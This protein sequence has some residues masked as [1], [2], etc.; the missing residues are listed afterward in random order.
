MPRTFFRVF[1]LLAITMLLA[2]LMPRAAQPVK[3]SA[4]GLVI[5]QVYGGGGNS[6]ATYT[7]DFVELF[8]AGSSNVSLNGLSVQYASATGAFTA[9]SKADLPNVSLQP[10]QYFLIQMA[11]GTGGSQP[12]PTPDLVGSSNMSGTA[13]KVALVNGTT[14]ISC[15]GTAGNC[16]SDTSIIDLV[17]FG[18]TANNYEGSG[19]TPAPSNTNSV[20]RLDG[21]CTDT[22]NNSADFE[23]ITAYQTGNPRNTSTTLAPC[24]SPVDNPPAV[25]STTPA[26]GAS[27]VALNS[28]ISITFNEAVTTSASAFNLTCTTGGVRTFAFGGSGASYTLTPDTNLLDSDSCTVTVSAAG[29]TDLDGTPDNMAADYTFSFSTVAPLVCGSAPDKIYELQENGSKYGLGGSFTVDGVVTYSRLGIGGINGFYIQDPVGDGNPNTS[30]AIFVFDPAPVVLNVN[31]GD[32]V[33]ITGTVSEFAQ[34]FSDLQAGVTSVTETQFNI[35]AGELCTNSASITPTVVTLP[36]SSLDEQER[37]EGMLVTFNQTLYVT[38][39]FQL[40]RYGEVSLSLGGRLFQPTNYLTPGAAAITQQQLNNRSRIILDDANKNQ[41]VDPIVFPQPAGLSASNTLRHGDSVASVTGVYVQNNART[42]NGTSTNLNPFRYRLYPTS[43]VTFIPTNPRPTSAPNVGGSIKVAS[44][45]LLNYFNTFTGCYL[46]GGFA[47]GNCRGAENATEFTRQRNKTI[48]AILKMNAAVLGVNELENDVVN[49]NG[50]SN[51]ATIAMQDL[52]DGLN[53][54]TA[55]GTYAYI[56]T[57]RIGSDAI[58]VG[59]IYQ[60]ALVTPV[61]GFAVLDNVDPFNRNTRPPLA[62]TFQEISSGERFTVVVNH[63][64]SKGSCPSNPTIDPTYGANHDTGDGQGCWNADRLR[65]ANELRSWIATN[66]YFTDPDVLIMGDLNSYAAEDPITYF[67]SNGWT[68]L[69]AHFVGAGN[70]AYS[71]VFDGQSGYLDHM[72]ANPTLLS[73]VSGAADYH[74]NA[75]EPSVLDYNTNFKTAGQQVSLYAADEFRTSDHD[76][77]ILGLNLTAADVLITE[78]DGSTAVTEGGA[79]DQYSVVLN[80]TPSANVTVSLSFDAQVEVSVDSGSSYQASPVVL[81]FTPANWNTAQIVLVRAVDDAAVEGPHASSIT[82]T[83]A[84]A[85]EFAGIANKLV[86]VSITDND[87]VAPPTAGVTVNPTSVDVD[88]DG[89]TDQY[90]VVLDA[91]PTDD[92]VITLSY[93]TQITTDVDTLTFTSGNWNIPQTVTITA[94]D[95]LDDE[96]AH[97][98]T[99]T[100]SAASADVDYDGISV[101]SVTVNIADND[102]GVIAPVNLIVNGSFEVAGASPQRAANWMIKR[103]PAPDNRRICNSRITYSS[104]GNC[105]YRLKATAGAMLTRNLRQVILAPSVQ[106]GD[107]LL[108]R[109]DARARLLGKGARVRVLVTYPSGT[110]TFIRAIPRGSYAYR[111][112]TKT[113]TLTDVPT[114]ITVFVEQRAAG[115]LFFLD[116]VQLLVNAPVIRGPAARP[117]AHTD[118]QP[119][120]LPPAQ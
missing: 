6:G 80:K 31:V 42:G 89:L 48:A 102:G 62:Q 52:V 81:T 119:L 19:P 94:E 49:D 54:A 77:V 114:R 32:Y 93:G 85:A 105:A 90:T 11:A 21:G 83:I 99:I 87:T 101:A 55:P 111:T 29:V 103:L 113:Y 20:R 53:A 27:N 9:G 110:A 79:V 36:F 30:D 75:D 17:G 115:G 51:G 67:L 66:A 91:A 61:G 63:F 108:L 78:S 45:N 3:A 109:F 82:H 107:E 64:K 39:M 104:E 43:P 12:L 73:Q 97:T 22:D 95:D 59:L 47:T 41:N 120:P 92:V 7:H 46:N 8:N 84:G 16:A 5:S 86:N 60:P 26:N 44:F 74:I 24:G 106:A 70:V 96:G 18:T 117:A 23:A 56:D 35:T 14:L 88:E 10:G 40:G 71:Y 13:G 72:L 98:E 4:S 112:L 50:G 68:N 25:S 118:G 34:N 116:N 57:G 37:Y 38:E 33:R 15:G 69:I 65:A 2:G 100:H 76:P 1:G 58:R 28:T